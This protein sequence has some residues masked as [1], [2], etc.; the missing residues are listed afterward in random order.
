MFTSETK[1]PTPCWVAGLQPGGAQQR[2]RNDSAALARPIPSFGDERRMGLQISLL[3]SLTLSKAMDN[4]A[5]SR[6]NQ[7]GNDPGRRTS[8][9]SPPNTACPATTSRTTAPPARLVA[10]V[11]PRQTLGR[12]HVAGDGSAGRWL[13]NRRNQH[14]HT[15]RDGDLHLFPPVNAQVSAITNDFSGAN[16]YRPNVTCDPY[17]PA[18]QQTINNW[19]NSACV[20]APTDPSQPFGNA[21]RNTVRGPNYM[22]FD[23]AASKNFALGGQMRLQFRSRLQ[24]VQPRQLHGA[25][26]QL[27][28]PDVRHHHVNLR[29]T[30]ASARHQAA[31]VRTADTDHRGG[32][33]A[34]PREAVPAGLR[35]AV[36]LMWFVSVVCEA[37]SWFAKPGSFGIRYRRIGFSWGC[38]GAGRFEGARSGAPRRSKRASGGARSRR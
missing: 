23:M 17:A 30:P 19:F 20:S 36:P 28:Q 34:A 24:P 27:Q 5:R 10:A 4:G 2:G 12:Q 31:L 26:G 8:T 37:S 7:N 13:G 16:S 9:T 29:R 21:A 38:G 11:W 33:F 18:G 15:R 25:R 6:E 14:H 32:S 3:S 22:T 35:V 1:Q